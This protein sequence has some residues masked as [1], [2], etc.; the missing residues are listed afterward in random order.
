MPGFCRHLK[1][2]LYCFYSM[3]S[4]KKNTLY[5][6]YSMFS[7]N[8]YERQSWSWTIPSAWFTYASFF[9]MVPKT[10][11]PFVQKLFCCRDHFKSLN[12]A[13]TLDAW[14]LFLF[15]AAP[16]NN[17]LLLPHPND[18]WIR[19]KKFLTLIKLTFES[20][21][22]AETLDA[23]LLSLCFAAPWNNILILPCPFIGPNYIWIRSKNFWH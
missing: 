19:S 23:W 14:H 22:I 4:K 17:I 12:I 6:F 1:T 7:K 11:P 2:T 5:C 16:W 18:I 9:V 15:F 3:F 20:L 21:N 13:E 10:R 8:F